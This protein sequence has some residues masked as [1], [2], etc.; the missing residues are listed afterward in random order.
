MQFKQI[1]DLSLRKDWVRMEKWVAAVI[2]HNIGGRNHSMPTGPYENVV[3]DCPPKS[4]ILYCQPYYG[5]SCMLND[6]RMN[7]GKVRSRSSGWMGWKSFGAYQRNVPVWLRS[8]CFWYQGWLWRTKGGS[9]PSLWSTLLQANH[10]SFTVVFRD[11]LTII[12][13]QYLVTL[14]FLFVPDAYLY[15]LTTEYNVC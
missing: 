5:H 8:L 6:Q 10:D 14:P 13:I 12:I 4:L 11:M 15:S 2:I 9:H 3:W 7:W 1:L